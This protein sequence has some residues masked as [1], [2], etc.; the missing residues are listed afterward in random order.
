M[1][2]CISVVSNTILKNCNQLLLTSHS[3]NK[4]MPIGKKNQIINKKYKEEEKKK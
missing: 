4:S 3:Y 2:E 1:Q